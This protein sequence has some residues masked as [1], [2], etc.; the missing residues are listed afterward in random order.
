MKKFLVGVPV[1]AAVVLMGSTALHAQSTETKSNSASVGVA[2]A[3]DT[4]FLTGGQVAV[5]GTGQGS[6][7][8]SRSWGAINVDGGALSTY[9]AD[10][11]GVNRTVPV[12][13]SSMVSTFDFLRTVDT[14]AALVGIGSVTAQG[15]SIGG[16]AVLGSSEAGSQIAGTREA[17]ANGVGGGGIAYTAGD[18]QTGSANSSTS[19]QGSLVGSFNTTNTMQLMGTGSLFAGSQA[20]DIGER[21]AGISAANTGNI[22]PG[23]VDFSTMTASIPTNV[24]P[25][26]SGTGAVFASITE[27]AGPIDINVANAGNG[28]ILVS[29]STGGFFSEG[30]NAGVAGEASSSSTN[31]FFSNPFNNPVN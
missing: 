3:G 17:A 11:G 19:A 10:S 1:A 2:L 22:I 31:G 16:I 23:G 8:L 18:V 24:A 15:E 4:G 9:N 27:L 30:T 21:N 7:V 28:S 20:L 29:G 13:E 5:N 25:S 12:T 14:G 26:A 6:V